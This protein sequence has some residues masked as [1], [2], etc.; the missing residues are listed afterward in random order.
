MTG[1]PSRTVRVLIVDDEPD[2]R[3]LLRTMLSLDPRIEIAGEAGDGGRG[4][5]LYHEL[6]PDVLVLDQRMPVLEGLEVAAL[7]L[8]EDP[9][10]L[11]VLISAYLDD[12]MRSEA[13][14]LG[15]RSIMGKQH[16]EEIGAEILRLAS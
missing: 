6:R 12:G 10:Q 3:L 7:V 9:E 15:V 13:N 5:E 1:E 4:L 14:D 16:I 8:A 2:L 11:I